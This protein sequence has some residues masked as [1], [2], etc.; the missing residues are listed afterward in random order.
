MEN[1]TLKT[2]N[3]GRKINQRKT[4]KTGRKK[5]TKR[6]LAE[7]E[8]RRKKDDEK[9]Q[10]A[11]MSLLALPVFTGDPWTQESVEVMFDREGRELY[12]LSSSWIH[13][14]RL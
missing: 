6:Q 1:R 4:A 13:P 10:D 7:E 14:V 11:E 3:T 2:E 12:R 5:P 9:K 8:R